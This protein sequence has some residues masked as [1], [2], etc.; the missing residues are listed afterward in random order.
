[1]IGSSRP[2]R[3]RQLASIDV[4]SAKRALPG[5][6]VRVAWDETVGSTASDGGAFEDGADGAT[7]CPG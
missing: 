2:W 7:G 4:I 3:G 6:G 1:M 5:Q